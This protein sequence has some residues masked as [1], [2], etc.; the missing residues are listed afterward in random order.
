MN[1]GTGH[2]ADET[3]ERLAAS[4]TVTLDA[5]MGDV[6][7]D[8]DLD[9]LEGNVGFFGV[10]EQNRL[11]I[12]DGTGRFVDET[13]ARLPATQ[14][15]TLA[16][17]FADVDLDSDLDIVVANGSPSPSRILINDG[18]GVFTDES[19]TRLSPSATFLAAD[20]KIADIDGNGS[21]DLMFAVVTGG[22]RVFMN[23]GAGVFAD[24]TSTRTPTFPGAH[25]L[26]LTDVDGDQDFDVFVSTPPSPGVLLINNGA[27]VFTDATAAS[28][29][30]LP[31]MI[32]RYP[33]CGDMD[34]DGDPDLYLPTWNPL[35]DRDRLLMN[36]GDSVVLIQDLIDQVTGLDLSAGAANPLLK[37]LN[38]ALAKLEDVNPN[39][40]GAARGDLRGFVSTVEA[41]AGRSIDQSDAQELIAAANRILMRMEQTVKCVK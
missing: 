35:P 14:D 18:S 24:E 32:V 6:D 15:I 13:S 22:P 26:A 10:G 3:A 27:G 17:D 29:P 2:F 8:G 34:G 28:I 7:G 23:N 16:V 33:L 30:V 19:S 5:A 36:Q 38:A 41:K 39:N 37:L 12:N 40:N 11:L 1:D 25:G 4:I 9:I 20:V 21:P 31:S